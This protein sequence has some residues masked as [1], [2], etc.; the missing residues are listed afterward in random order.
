MLLCRSPCSHSI[1][2]VSNF[3]NCPILHRLQSSPKIPK[4]ACFPLVQENHFN[5][6]DSGII[7]F[8]CSVRLGD[9]N[10]LWKATHTNNST[11]YLGPKQK[12]QPRPGVEPF[13]GG[14]Y[15]DWM[16]VFVNQVAFKICMCLKK[17]CKLW[18]YSIIFIY[19]AYVYICIKTL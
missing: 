5:Q 2:H 3:K 13:A 17:D 6:L 9:I 19:W 18:T 10:I 4:C 16:H 1:D 14:I 12:R 11:S 15:C 8:C 7:N